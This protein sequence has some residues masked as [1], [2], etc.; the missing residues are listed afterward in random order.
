MK[1]VG[2]STALHAAVLTWGLWSLGS[3]EPLEMGGESVPVTLISDLSEA[4]LGDEKAPEAEISAPKPTERPET[5]LVDAQNVGDNK[6]DLDT[7]PAPKAAPQESVKTA[8]AEA[9]PPP[10]PA[11]EP[12]PPVPTP[13]PVPEPT[14]A[15]PEVTEA[16]PDVPTPPEPPT[17]IDELAELLAEKPPEPPAPPKNVPMPQAKPRP[18]EPVK[19]AEKPP[20][21]KPEP[22]K[23]AVKTPEKTKTPTTSKS[24]EKTKETKTTDSQKSTEKNFEDKVAALLNKQDSAG[25]GSKGSTQTASL[26]A[27]KATG[28]TLSQ[29]E[30]D[31]L[32]GQ[33]EKCWS[34]PAGN[35]DAGSFRVKV[36][37]R[38]KPT[39]DVDGMPEILEG[40]S[41]STAERAAGEA[42]LRA[43][44]RCAPY[45]LPAEKYDT[46]SEVTI[47]FDPSQM[48]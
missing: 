2:I 5:P 41:G 37:M 23:E 34:P 17:E 4:T 28:G 18:P 33:M 30:L 22:V 38:L 40:G 42:A 35:A 45:N 3:P 46:W 27:K 9:P 20:E 13:A 36:S 10:P 39:G 15:P 8:A 47:N 12:T 43:I 14:P 25:G 21:P 19:V 48:F 26:G 32:K 1:S 29:S 31:A 6:V 24:T 44:R 7:P 16:K 11:A